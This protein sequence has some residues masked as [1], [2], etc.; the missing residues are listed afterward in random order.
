MTAVASPPRGLMA[1][2]ADGRCRRECDV[3]SRANRCLKLVSQADLREGAEHRQSRVRSSRFETGPPLSGERGRPATGQHAAQID[4]RRIFVRFGSDDTACAVAFVVRPEPAH[5]D[6]KAVV[7][8]AFAR[9]TGQ[10]QP[11]IL[12]FWART[13]RYPGLRQ[14]LAGACLS[15]VERV[16]EVR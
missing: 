10:T 7:A 6:E 3:S 11:A 13:D 12:R 14:Q 9:A 15:L 2:K 8:S 16:T 4:P 1:G 5:L